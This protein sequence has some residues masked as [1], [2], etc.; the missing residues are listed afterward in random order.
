MVKG[1][2]ALPL[3]LTWTA[4]SAA[5]AVAVGACSSGSQRGGSTADATPDTVATGHDG[6]STGSDAPIAMDV[7]VDTSHPGCEAFVDGNAIGFEA[8]AGT[9]PDGDTTI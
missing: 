1:R 7:S 4:L 6:A 5:G 9:C 2:L 8:D 3:V